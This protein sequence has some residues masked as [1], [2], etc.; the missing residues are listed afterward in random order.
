MTGT[1]KEWTEDAE[2]VKARS[3]YDIAAEIHK[4]T[5]I[6]LFDARMRNEKAE[7]ILRRREAQLIEA[8][9]G[10]RGEIVLDE[11]RAM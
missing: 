11:T 6:A 1:V 2:Y 3:R 10:A 7:R 8:I 5:E 4:H 9:R